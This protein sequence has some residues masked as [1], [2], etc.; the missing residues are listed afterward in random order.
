MLGS[1]FA[2]HHHVLGTVP[3]SWSE[4]ARR[5]WREVVDDD[6]LGLAAQLAYYFF[7]ALF[8]A[9]L[10]VLALASFFP[11]TNLSDDVTRALGPVAPAEVLAFFEGQLQRLS[12][13][14]SGGILTIG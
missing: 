8:P 12:N 5:T 6:V 10:F 2:F 7:L 4:L 3:L 9:V 1:S 11:L 13:A 14:D